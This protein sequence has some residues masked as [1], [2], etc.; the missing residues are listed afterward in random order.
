MRGHALEPRDASDTIVTAT[1][2]GKGAK[3]G[4]VHPSMR[5]STVGRLPATGFRHLGSTP[6]GFRAMATAGQWATR[7]FLSARTPKRASGS[8]VS[9][10]Q[11]HARLS[12][13]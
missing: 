5:E 1:G 11:G 13:G 10:H 2:K 7:Q 6:S 8:C 12:G 4:S 3:R 9:S